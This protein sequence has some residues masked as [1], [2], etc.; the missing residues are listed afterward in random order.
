MS[1]NPETTGR[2]GVETPATF[3]AGPV[4]LMHDAA[5]EHPRAATNERDSPRIKVIMHPDD[6]HSPEIVAEFV[7]A[8][9]DE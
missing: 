2:R 4:A 3:G 9:L 1:E 8:V 5:P 6:A 7:R